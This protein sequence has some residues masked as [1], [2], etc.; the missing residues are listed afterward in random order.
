MGEGGGAKAIM[1]TTY[2][3]MGPPAKEKNEARHEED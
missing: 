2:D 1:R 3:S